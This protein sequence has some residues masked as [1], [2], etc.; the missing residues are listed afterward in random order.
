MNFVWVCGIYWVCN[1]RLSDLFY[2]RYDISFTLYSATLTF[3]Q[4]HHYN[5][6]KLKGT[7]MSV[8]GESVSAHAL[9]RLWTCCECDQPK[10]FAYFANGT[11][12]RWRSSYIH[13]QCWIHHSYSHNTFESKSLSVVFISARFTFHPI[14]DVCVF[15]CFI[16][17]VY[18]A[19]HYGWF[20]AELIKCPKL[21]RT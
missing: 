6:Y 19:V 16:S 5:T 2:L 4:F 13:K 14:C 20:Q 12:Q 21:N 1:K 11:V 17:F 3:F 9:D 15:F 7:K 18:I 10:Y 8:I